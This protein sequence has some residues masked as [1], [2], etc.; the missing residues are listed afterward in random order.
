MKKLPWRGS[1][2]F[3]AT[4]VQSWRSVTPRSWARRECVMSHSKTKNMKRLAS[5]PAP[6]SCVL[7]LGFRSTT[8]EPSCSG[9]GEHAGLPWETRGVGNARRREARYMEGRSWILAHGA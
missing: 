7:G 9:S 6:S 4:P 1:V 2:L 5:F 8:T 3:N